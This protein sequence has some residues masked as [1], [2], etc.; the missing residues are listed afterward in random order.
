MAGMLYFEPKNP[1]GFSTLKRMHAAERGKK[2][3]EQRFWL[4]A[5]DA[6]TLHRPVRKRF[7]RNSY[8]VNNIMY[9]WECDLVDV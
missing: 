9:V 7:Q 1:S 4:E 5:Q 8:N 6:Y 2:S 3:G